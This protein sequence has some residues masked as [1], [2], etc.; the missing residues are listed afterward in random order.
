[1]IGISVS[2]EF[3]DLPE[4]MIDED[5]I[6][7]WIEARLNAARNLFIQRVSRQV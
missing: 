2:I 1:M 4:P 7:N 3:D 6:S 5:G